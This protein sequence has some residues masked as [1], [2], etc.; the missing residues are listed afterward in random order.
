MPS[1]VGSN[2]LRNFWSYKYNNDMDQKGVPPH[3]DLA[4]VNLNVW[5]TPDDAN[6]DPLT[7]GMIVYTK[8]VADT[9]EKFL[10][11]Q[12]T[13]EDG[14]SDSSSDACSSGGGGGRTCT[15]RSGTKVPYKRNRMVIFD[16]SI[17]HQTS[18]IQFK[19]GYKNKRINLTWL[20]GH[21]VWWQ[22]WVKLHPGESF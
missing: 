18:P 1:V 2:V 9:R 3:A 5:I 19:K 22:E 13:Y 20:F 7:G 16:S 11:S 12:R 17:V 14:R 4:K 21:P 10:T 15:D 8:Q 6:L